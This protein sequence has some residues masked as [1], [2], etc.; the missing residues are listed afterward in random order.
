MKKIPLLLAAILLC[1]TFIF[2]DSTWAA[3]SANNAP[4]KVVITP[5][6]AQK[7]KMVGNRMRFPAM[8]AVSEASR[9]FLESVEWIELPCFFTPFDKIAQ[10]RSELPTNFELLQN[11]PNPFN[12]STVIGYTLPEAAEVRLEIFNLAGQRIACP[13]E[14]NQSAGRHQITWEG[15]DDHGGVVATG[16]YF[17]RLTA[18]D[19][20]DVKKMNLVK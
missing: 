13:F 15:T 14:G 9:A 4:E 17:C 18:G 10:E 19:F 20:S 6:M 16:V 12:L 8:D 1:T 11:Y 7:I 5:E 3:Q 2:I